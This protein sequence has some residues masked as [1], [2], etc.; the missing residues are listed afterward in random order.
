[1]KV[2]NFPSSVLKK[3]YIRILIHLLAH[4]KRALQKRKLDELQKHLLTLQT[5]KNPS[6]FHIGYK[7][8]VY[9]RS[10]SSQNS[11]NQKTCLVNKLYSIKS[12][13]ICVDR[14]SNNPARCAVKDGSNPVK[15]ECGDCGDREEYR[16]GAV[17]T[18]GAATVKQDR[19]S[20]DKEITAII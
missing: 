3:N 1:M 18:S 12:M 2:Q 20:R 14:V 6:V 11:F 15:L 19:N 17:Q 5:K 8:Y 16:I 13:M 10:C 9:I 4:K 7:T